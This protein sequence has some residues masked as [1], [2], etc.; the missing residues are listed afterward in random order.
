MPCGMSHFPH[1]THVLN[2]QLMAKARCKL[3]L[4]FCN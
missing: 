3:G 1:L 2:V 4:D